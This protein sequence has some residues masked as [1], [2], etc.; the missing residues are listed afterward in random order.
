MFINRL[1]DS[2]QRE[3][4][5]YHAAYMQLDAHVCQWIGVGKKSKKPPAKL[6]IITLV[7]TFVLSSVYLCRQ[8]PCSGLQ[9]WWV[10]VKVSWSFQTVL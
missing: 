3:S 9:K 6:H 7:H 1:H 4:T 10:S 8:K 5:S 2:C